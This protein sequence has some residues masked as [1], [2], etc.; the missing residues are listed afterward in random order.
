MRE[1]LGRMRA[2]LRRFDC[3]ESEETTLAA[4]ELSL[5]RANTKVT[6]HGRPVELTHW[7]FKFGNPDAGRRTGRASGSL[8]YTLIELGYTGSDYFVNPHS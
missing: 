7:N 3:Q 8:E 6:V 4:G 1:L 2:V 5:D